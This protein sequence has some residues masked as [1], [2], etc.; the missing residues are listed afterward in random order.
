M[1]PKEAMKIWLARK[2]PGCDDVTR[3]VSDSMDRPQGFRKWIHIRLHMLICE[4]CSRYEIQ[5]KF[6]RRLLGTEL[7]VAP[8]SNDQKEKMKAA[9]RGSRQT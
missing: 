2:L 6:I 7:P 3:S 4:V 5:L 1:E 8:L 9:L